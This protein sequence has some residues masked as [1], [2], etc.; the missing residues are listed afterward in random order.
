MADVVWATYCDACA[1]CQT[2]TV[3]VGGTRSELPAWR[4]LCMASRR[5][6][7]NNFVSRTHRLVEP[8]YRCSVVNTGD[9]RLYEP[10]REVA[11]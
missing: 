2:Y 9:C 6:D 3:S 8:Y 7:T 5:D 10:R 1:N 11:T 4:W